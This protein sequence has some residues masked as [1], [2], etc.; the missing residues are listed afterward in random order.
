MFVDSGA[1][2]TV[3]IGKQS[4]VVDNGTGTLVMPA[5]SEEVLRAPLLMANHRIKEK[6]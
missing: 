2:D 3:V 4:I 6:Q 5:R 1:I